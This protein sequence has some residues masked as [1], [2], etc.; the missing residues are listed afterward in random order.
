MRTIHLSIETEVPDNTL[1]TIALSPQIGEG[2]PTR[3][4]ILRPV[5]SGS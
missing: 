2:V 1:L 3:H 4:E 5:L